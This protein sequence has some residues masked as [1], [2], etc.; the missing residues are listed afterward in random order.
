MVWPIDIAPRSSG[1]SLK[2]I[3]IVNSKIHDYNEFDAGNWLG[4]GEKPHSDGIFVRTADMADVIWEDILIAGNDFYSDEGANSQ[5]GTAA[6]YVSQGP[7][8]TIINN[9]FRGVR[10]T[11]TIGVGH[12]NPTSSP[13]QIVNIANN[14]FVDSNKAILMDGETNTFKREVNILN[15]IFVNVSDRANSVS[16]MFSELAPNTLDYNIYYSP[17]VSVQNNYVAYRNGYFTFSALQ[18]AGFEKNGSYLN[19]RLARIDVDISTAASS[20]NA[21]PLSIS[22]ALKRGKPLD[23]VATDKAGLERNT[24][25]P[26]VGAYISPALPTPQGFRIK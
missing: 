23:Y 7:S 9:V 4:C 5:G 13:K 20:V 2:R 22:P 26:G 15:N 17:L 8:L 14:T 16:V 19:P 25:T 24:L 1:V 10:H 12:W 18:G 21:M 3:H 11:R 6:I